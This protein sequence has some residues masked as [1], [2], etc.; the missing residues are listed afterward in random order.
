MLTADFL[1]LQDSSS[2]AYDEVIVS[3]EV[4]LLINVLCRIMFQFVENKWKV[5]L[6][7]LQYS[8]QWEGEFAIGQC[9]CV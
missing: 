2:Q 4:L 1:T 7:W 8:E 9:Q 3:T 5:K 6:Y